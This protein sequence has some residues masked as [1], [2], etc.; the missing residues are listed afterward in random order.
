M[1]LIERRMAARGGGVG[2]GAQGERHESYRK[3]VCVGTS[4]TAVQCLINA[5]WRQVLPNMEIQPPCQKER[6]YFTQHRGTGRSGFTV[7]LR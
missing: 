2:V 4:E 5:P 3:R 6:P 1:L 7:H